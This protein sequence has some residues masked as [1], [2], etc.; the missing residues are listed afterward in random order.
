MQ[1]SNPSTSLLATGVRKLKALSARTPHASDAQDEP[2][3]VTAQDVPK[4]LEF[5]ATWYRTT[6]GLPDMSDD[7]AW[8]NYVSQGRALGRQ[9]CPFFMPRYVEGQLAHLGIDPGDDLIHTYLANSHNVSPHILLPT[10]PQ[11]VYPQS[12]RDEIAQAG[13]FCGSVALLRSFDRHDIRHSMLFDPSFVVDADGHPVDHPLRTHLETGWTTEAQTSVY[14]DPV[15]YGAIY[16]QARASVAAGEYTNLLDHFVNC[17]S[18]MGMVPFGDFDAEFYYAQNPDVH[19][20]VKEGRLKSGADHFIFHGAPEGRNP[21]PFFDTNYYLTAQPD[22]P[23]QMAQ[24]NLTS[25]FEHFLKVGKD[26]GYKAHAPL[27]SVPVPVMHGKALY[28]KRCRVTAHDIVRYKKVLRFRPPGDQV[29][30]SCI[31]PVHDHFDMTLHL[32]DQLATITNTTDAPGIEVIVVDDASEDLTTELERYTEGVVIERRTSAGGYPIACNAG[33]ARARGDVLV[34]LNNDIEINALSLIG[35]AQ[36]VA[37]H[38]EIGALGPKII[39][40]N[41]DLQ[42]AGSLVFSEGGTRGV[43][44]D[45][46]FHTINASVLKEVDFCSGCCFFIRRSVFKAADGFD[47]VFAPGYYEETDLCLRLAEQGLPTVFHPEFHVYHYEYASYSKNRPPLVSAGRMAVNRDHLVDAHAPRLATLALN[48]DAETPAARA[49]RRLR[50]NVAVLEDFLPDPA[51]GSGFGRAN[52]V[53]ETLIDMRCGVTVFA[54]NYM[55]TNHADH[56]HRLGVETV[57]LA[58][59]DHAEALASRQGDFDLLWLCRT[60]NIERCAGFVTAMKEGNPDLKV[61][62]DTEA[63]STFREIALQTLQGHPP[64]ETAEALVAAELASPYPLDAI[65]TVNQ[66]DRTAAQAAVACPVFELPHSVAPLLNAGDATGRNGIFFCGAFHDVQTPNYD[67]LIWFLEEIWPAV[68]RERPSETFRFSGFTGKGVD[69]A[70]LAERHDGVEYLGCLDSIMPEMHKARVFV[71]PTRYSGGIPIKV[72]ESVAFGLPCVCT[73]LLRSQIVLGDGVAT[74][75]PALSSPVNDAQAF[76]R[77]CVTLLRDDAAWT[78]LQAQGLS[79]IAQNA[80][81]DV[82]A[83]NLEAILSV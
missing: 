72:M 77:N 3:S 21:N 71:A 73:D 80:S 5:D 56:L 37:D 12:L 44:R 20:A 7:D 48:S 31:I 81:R 64:A 50:P 1:K 82:I 51:F 28:E 17:G 79:Y 60:H 26:R 75:M 66:N 6:Y 47:E 53:I 61:I 13:L 41:G 59:K 32:L 83:E 25:A 27:Y 67:G 39:Q 74:D 69:L 55:F 10:A 30:L 43:A 8:Q 11:G 40:M 35:A 76:A 52:A 42:E 22:V 15:F 38:P 4:E 70:A 14:F 78:A 49:G 23:G 9:P 46:P 45:A 16:P 33:A 19:A 29:A 24:M 54:L 36:Y 63:L 34:F 57:I 2:H 68:R 18:A 65:V 62:L 58:G